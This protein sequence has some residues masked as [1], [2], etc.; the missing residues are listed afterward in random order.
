MNIIYELDLEKVTTIGIK[1]KAVGLIEVDTIEHLHQTFDY[2]HNEDVQAMLLGNGSN[3][4]PSKEFITYYLIKIKKR[5][6]FHA[7]M[8]HEK[9]YVTARGGD[10][11]KRFVMWCADKGLKGVECLAGIPGTIGGAVKMNAGSFGGEIG[12]FVKEISVWHE[13]QGLLNFKKEEIDFSY[14]N[15]SLPLEKGH[16]CIWEV[17]FEFSRQ[18]PKIVKSR[19]RENYM[20]KKSTQPVLEKSCGCVFKNPG[21][22]AAGYLLEK[23]GLKRK[24]IGDMEFSHLHA[25]F[26]INRGKGTPAQAMELIEIGKKKVFDKFGINLELEVK[27]I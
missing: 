14:R 12:D 5:N 7:K 9:V 13:T 27:I 1:S 8:A 6:E 26:L 23:A 15:I 4:I 18:D 21:G 25:N 10:S 20:K 3:I 19:I 22:Y 16:W 24:R 17:I 2:I 11:L